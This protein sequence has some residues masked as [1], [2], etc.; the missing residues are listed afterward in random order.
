[1]TL[2]KALFG[3]FFRMANKMNYQNSG[4]PFGIT[5]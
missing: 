3:Y 5:A 2:C 4:K 1:M